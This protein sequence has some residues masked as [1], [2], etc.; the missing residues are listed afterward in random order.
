MWQPLECVRPG[1]LRPCGESPDGRHLEFFAHPDD[2]PA[3]LRDGATLIDGLGGRR[4]YWAS[5]SPTPRYANG[6]VQVVLKEVA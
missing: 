6:D 3:L 5:L 1:E 2:I 4:R